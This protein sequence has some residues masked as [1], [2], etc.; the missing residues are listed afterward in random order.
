MFA[1]NHCST[2]GSLQEGR[3]VEGGVVVVPV[4]VPV[5]VR[6]LEL[7]LNVEETHSDRAGD[8]GDRSWIIRK[9]PMPMVNQAAA[10][11]PAIA[12]LVHQ[13]DFHSRFQARGTSHGKRCLTRK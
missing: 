9:G 6:V 2:L 3:A 13:T 1:V 5:P 7:M 12:A 8:Q 11:I 10:R 4:L